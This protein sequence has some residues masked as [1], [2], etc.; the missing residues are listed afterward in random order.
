MIK[1]SFGIRKSDIINRRMFIIGAAKIIIFGGLIARLFSLQINDNKKYLTLSDKNRIREWKLPPTRGNIVDY[2]GNVIAG[3]LKVY[4]LHVIPEQVE[5]FNYLISR[6]RSILQLSEK[7]VEKIKK[8]KNQLKPWESLI[9]SENLSWS[10]FLKINN[11]LYELVGVKPVM[12][13]SRNYPFNDI[14]THVLGYVSQPNEDD[15]LANEVIKE[16]FVPGIKVGKLGLEKTLENE[17]IGVNDIQRYEVN[18]YGKR[19]NQLEYQKGK[20]G[21]KIRITLDTEVQKLCAELLVNKAGSISV[22]D[23]YTGEVIALYSSPSYDPNLFLF[24]ISQDEWQ[25]IR[26]NPLKPLINK[27]L[28]GLYSPGSTIKPIVALSA[29]ENNIIDTNFK[30]R[31][32]GKIE[33]HGQ[34]FHCWKEKGHGTVNLKD[35]MKQSCDTYFYEIAR[36]LGVDRLKIT[37]DKFGLGK[38]VLGA[39]FENE[40]SGQFPDTEWKK[41]N[42]GKGWV[43]GETLITGIGQ[44]YTQT[45]PIQ[46]CLMTAQIAN[47]GYKIN[48]KIITDDNQLTSEEIKKAVQKN[49]FQPNLPLFDN[50]NNIKIVQKAMFSS[51][52][53]LRGTSYRSRIEDPKYQ[54]AGKTGTAQVKRISKRERELDLKTSQI[55]YNERDHALYVAF[56]PYKNPRYALSIIV[57][58]GGS[59]S[60]TAAPMATKL[61]KLIIDRHEFRK[62]IPDFKEFDI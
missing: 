41:N 29:L 4:Q 47:G 24:G 26:N 1:G 38:K 62:K 51:T 20:Q 53:E 23:I 46:L 27:T 36:K 31:C 40:K 52:N 14:Y 55:P 37:A 42:L 28:S 56:G 6:L 43:L 2:F 32:K 8:K 15:I 17:L 45:T 54:F 10:E 33:L 48:P 13:I 35:A 11:Y 57:E 34:T 58:H 61:F 5:N 19:I 49:N 39:Y 12:T 7:R 22:M 18:A 25:L 21:S 16:K 60:S 50:Q 30:V 3:N 44:G 59:G 9:I